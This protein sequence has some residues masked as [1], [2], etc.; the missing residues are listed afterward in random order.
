[1]LIRPLEQLRRHR[2]VVTGEDCQEAI[3]RAPRIV[4]GICETSPAGALGA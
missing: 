4:Y 3:W 2:E 1:V